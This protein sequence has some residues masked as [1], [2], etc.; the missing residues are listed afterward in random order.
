MKN[1]TS[2]SEIRERD[3]QFW[4]L[5]KGL[6]LRLVPG[7]ISKLSCVH[8]TEKSGWGVV[9][10][11]GNREELKEMGREFGRK[12]DYEVE[13]AGPVN[14]D[15]VL[16]TDQRIDAENTMA[17]H[18]GMI[19]K[20]ILSKAENISDRID[21]LDYGARFGKASTAVAGELE[22]ADD[23][24]LLDKTTFHLVETAETMVKIA[25]GALALQSARVS[26]IGKKREE[27]DCEALISRL[28]SESMDIIISLSSM[29]HHSFPD[30]MGE[31]FRVLKPGGF[32]V[33]GDWFSNAWCDP[34]IAHLLLTVIE[35]NDRVKEKFRSF[36]GMADE[37]EST[38]FASSSGEL[39][40]SEDKALIQHITYWKQIGEQMKRP[41]A[42]KIRRYFLGGHTNIPT[43]MQ[44]ME[45]A[46][47]IVD[48][49]KIRKAFGR[50]TLPKEP[51]R[52]IR[53]SD[54]AAVMIV[55]KPK[56][57]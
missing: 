41:D 29:H 3:E 25:N 31:M 19:V 35:V 20:E 4:E 33:S 6:P 1:A 55:R 27:D 42:P 56:S 45:K 40:T 10:T 34:T 46:G 13:R 48:M 37:H 11:P 54:F 38:S 2:I 7:S 24:N 26:T 12:D 36:F 57:R 21:V 49:A 50:G 8:M 14:V 39:V 16:T 47:F 43:R 28:D 23:G 32:V 18:M 30:Y 22:H 52:G 17:L 15:T 44:Q 5:T 51:I 53:G 9:V